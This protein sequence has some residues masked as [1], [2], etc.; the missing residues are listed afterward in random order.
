MISEDCANRSQQHNSTVYI[1]GSPHRARL[2][3]EKLL[4]EC[5]S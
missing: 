5:H 3:S 4:K 1:G 2:W